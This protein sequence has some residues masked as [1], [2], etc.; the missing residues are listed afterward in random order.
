MLGGHARLAS[1]LLPPGHWASSPRPLVARDVAKARE[2]LHGT[3]VHCTFLGSTDRLRVAIARVMAQDL[4]EAGIDADVVPLELG[5]LI[6]RLSAGD[7][8]AAVLQIPELAEPN[9]LRV[10]LHSSSMPPNGANRARIQD[11]EIDA[12]LDEG[13]EA[14]DLEARHAAYAKVE[15]RLLEHAYWI[16]LWHEDQIAVTSVR[17]KTFLPSAEGRWLGLATLP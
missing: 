2:L 17:A 6:A 1:G 13:A 12:A 8:D 16:P 3:R 4:A 15:A 11:A 10:F 7:F 5:T 14:L 9:T